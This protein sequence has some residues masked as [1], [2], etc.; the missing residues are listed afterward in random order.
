M[1]V[2]SEPASLRAKGYRILFIGDFNSH[3]G[4]TIG[5]GVEGNKD[6]I[7]LNGE[8][9]LS[10]LEEDSFC[11]INGQKHLTTG[12][13]TRQR[14]HSKSIVDYAVI[15]S[16]HL[17]TVHRMVI[18]DHGAFGGGSDHNF[19]FLNLNDKFIIRRQLLRL[20]SRKKSW[21]S[22]DNVN[23]DPF[24]AAVTERLDSRSPAELSVDEMA[25]FISSSLLS[26][27][28]RCIGVRKPNGA[29]V[30][31]S[32]PRDI[33]EQIKLK[34]ELE[35]EWKTL[36]VEGTT[37]KELLEEHEAKFLEQ[38][39]IV[40]D[41]LYCHRS[42][43]RPHLMKICSGK[44]PAARRHFWNAV[45]TKV[46]QSCDISAVVNP[47][48]GIL[49]CGVDEI[50]SE[51]ENHLSMV[52]EGS[53]VPVVAPPCAA[54][55]QSDGSH[56]Q[57]HSYSVKA[58]A[59]L[60]SIDSSSS[61]ATDPRGWMYMPFSRTEVK[62]I[63]RTLKGGK[64]AGWDT[65]PNEFL[66]NAPDCLVDWLTLLF[67]KIKS[68]GVMPKGWN[69]GRITL[70][71][72]SGL[73]EH[74][75]NY[76]PIT[77]IISMSGLFSKLLNSRLS[78][79]VES[80]CL[81]GEVQN[82]FRKDRRMADN[83]FIL[84]SILMKAKFYKQLVHLCYIDVAKAYVSVNRRILWSKLEAMGFCGEFLGCIKSL[85]EGDSVDTVINGMST[86][87]IYL[88]RGLRQGCSLSPLLFALY[89]SEIGA[90]LSRSTEGFALGGVTFSGL[91]FA[92]DIV[93]ISRTF[94]GLA[95][96][97][98]MVKQHCDD[99]K[100]VISEKK[101]NIVTYD[102][103]D[104]LVL[105]DE[106][107]EVAL[108]LSKIISYKYL[109]TET[110]LLMST[111]GVKRQH[112][113]VLTAKR[114]KFACSYVGRSGPDVV[115]T[116][117]ATWSNIAVPSMLSGCEVIPFSETSI[118]AIEAIQ[119]QL[120]KQTLGVPLSTANICAQTELGLRPFRML[121]YQHQL[122]FYVRVMN[123]HHSR[124]VRR[125]LVDHLEGGWSSPY[126]AKILKL[127]QKL[128]LLCAPPSIKFL[129]IHLNTWFI[130]QSNMEITRLKLPCV[131]QITKFGRA[132]YVCE[133]DG[134]SHI[135]RYKF[136]N[137]SLGNRA[138]RL[139]RCR[140][141]RCSLCS[142]VLDEVHVAFVC[143]SLDA[144]RL[145][146]TD[147]GVFV[148]LCRSKGFLARLAFKLYVT[149]LDWCGQAVPMSQYRKRG[150]I[151]KNVTR[152]WLRRT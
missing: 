42:R 107:N 80:H 96:L 40:N 121:L 6:D 49:K 5:R 55:N 4:V 35:H 138:P 83:S 43:N 26:A 146:N 17:S 145:A 93:L 48:S 99:L 110:T 116:V 109:G 58:T 1:V 111:T 141:N 41:L 91:L 84:D 19:I 115:D 32:L 150:V 106:Q 34:R 117:L 30:P 8:R 75:G 50:I 66:L 82:G 7:N 29:P 71:H 126:I 63:L 119:S 105:L 44:T 54:L 76:R 60:P 87:P 135:A 73:R 128:G 97:V 147:L 62:K 118:E 57:D 140:T 136:S 13:W 74:L 56:L 16:E 94:D 9:F 143:P 104:S 137:A 125:V 31:K 108:T 27:G 103:V 142:G 148:A 78:E 130:N 38:K 114:Y 100:L 131:A 152:E 151:L 15:S 65:I 134:C 88:R 89:I 61:I 98:K 149:G 144:Y 72:K 33:V 69:K 77:V 81:L 79:L 85:Y 10:F 68:E 70:I 124:W 132:D 92:D 122:N 21:N 95:E 133:A 113:C 86:R 129:K 2:R 112:R 37:T 36:V 24:R 46:K 3:V 101:S 64:S 120:A 123:L 18:D 22:M 45:S 90:D 67:N 47:A 59:A 102:D 12:L 53:F 14:G 25:S 28:E 11:H 51:A 39:Q 127:R 52:F 23:W 139:G 20:P